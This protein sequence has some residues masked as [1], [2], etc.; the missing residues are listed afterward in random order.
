MRNKILILLCSAF[1]F[2]CSSG[3]K[4]TIDGKFIGKEDQ[5]VYLEHL[6]TTGRTVVDS[7]TTNSKGEFKFT[8]K[9]SDKN[10]SFYNVK[11]DVGYIPL[12]V[13]ANDKISISSLCDLSKNYTVS[14]SK[15]SL[16]VKEFNTLMDECR[17]ELD[18]LSNAYSNDTSL[19][20]QQK[21]ALISEYSSRYYQFKRDHIKF[22]VTNAGDMSAIY[23]LYQRLP[24]DNTLFNGQ[25]DVIYYTMVADSIEVNYPGSPHLVALRS[26]IA[27]S[28][29]SLELAKRL[30][31]TEHSIT[32]YPNLN[33]PDMYGNN[34][35]LSEI[36]DGKVTLID[37]WITADN[38]SKILN[39]ELKE[40]Y[41]DY[42]DRGFEV[43][44][45]SLD[46]QKATWITA[47]QTQRLPWI[48]VCDFKGVSSTAV[49]MY[50]LQVV[51]SNILIGRDGDIIGQNLYGDALKAALSQTV[52]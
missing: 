49:S 9:M 13:S 45:V 37:F 1:I 47:V 36:A 14:G 18:S 42:K 15:S 6:S 50:N 40:L 21:A 12:I 22:I 5:S 39:A 51:P 3:H 10:P 19:D 25:G 46:T 43:Y 7:T 27:E 2:S 20:E 16:L 44:Q 35:S 11:Y 8:V 17:V 28:E 23:A 52:K 34:R 26:E 29:A 24:G 48:S 4:A 31:D 32:N 33:L 38:R 41:E 30:V